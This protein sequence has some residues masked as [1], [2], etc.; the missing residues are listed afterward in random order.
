MT[1]V[2]KAL[3]PAKQAE[4]AQ[5]TQYT[6]VLCKTIVDKFTVTNTSSSNVTL[7]VNL[8]ASGGSP[9]NSN[10]IIKAETIAPNECR[11]LSQLAGKVIEPGGFISTIASAATSLTIE[12]SG[13]E[14]T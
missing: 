7:S 9:G 6:A 11:A 1:V 14:I 10:L 4:N 2:I 5:T 13:R 3:V 8:V 12:A